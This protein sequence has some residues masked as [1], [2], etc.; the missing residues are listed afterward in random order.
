[1][2]SIT[3]YLTNSAGAPLSGQTVKLRRAGL[4][5]FGTEYLTM[6]DVAGKPGKYKTTSEYVTDRYKVWVN[7]TEDESFN[8]HKLNN[9]CAGINDFKILIIGT[10]FISIGTAL[11]Y[12]L[13]LLNGVQFDDATKVIADRGSILLYS[14]CIGGAHNFKTQSGTNFSNSAKKA[15]LIARFATMLI[16]FRD[17]ADGAHSNDECCAPQ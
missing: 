1:M 12:A 15:F 13:K 5:N 8:E 16:R 14:V 6:S 3:I 11:M 4:D 7:G 2:A 17:K 9:V 10:H